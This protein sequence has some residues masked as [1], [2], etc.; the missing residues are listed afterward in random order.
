MQ[1]TA[2]KQS[3]ITDPVLNR[4]ERNGFT[5]SRPPSAVNSAKRSTVR[6]FLF[7]PFHLNYFQCK[8]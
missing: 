8:G 7:F 5:N 4:L 2:L 6:D 3:T 1:L